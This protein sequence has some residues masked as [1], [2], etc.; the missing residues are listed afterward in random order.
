MW[1]REFRATPDT[2]EK[3]RLAGSLRK[4]GTS[5]YCSCAVFCELEASCHT[6]WDTGSTTTPPSISPRTPIGIRILHLVVIAVLPQ[7]FLGCEWHPARAIFSGC[8]DATC[9]RIGPSCRG[10]LGLDS[11]Q[12][13]TE[14]F[15]S[16]A[17][18][19]YFVSAVSKHKS[20]AP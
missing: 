1:P 17:D 10:K 18:A 14:L 11:R 3:Y 8:D 15:H 7:H 6:A 5:W 16:H 4:S 13:R 2:S 19:I 9:G 20:L 12:R